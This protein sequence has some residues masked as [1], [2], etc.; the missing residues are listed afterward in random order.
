MLK[1]NGSWIA[2][3]LFIDYG[4]WLGNNLAK[5][6]NNPDLI[7]FGTHFVRNILNNYNKAVNCSNPY[8]LKIKNGVVRINRDNNF[9][10]ISDIMKLANKT[11]KSFHKSARG[12][13]YIKDQPDHYLS[14]RGSTSGSTCCHPKLTKLALDWC[15][16]FDEKDKVYAFVDEAL[17][18]I[19]KEEEEDEDEDED[20]E[21]EEAEEE[22]EEGENEEEVEE[23]EEDKVEDEEESKEDEVEDE[24]ESKEYE[25]EDESVPDMKKN[26]IIPLKDDYEFK[27]K[28]KNG[29]SMD[30]LIRR[31]GYVN[32]T[33]LCKAGNKLFKHYNENKQ[34]KEYLQAL[35]SVVGIPTTD[36]LDIKQGGTNQGTYVHRK[37]AYHLAQWIS[38]HFAVQVSDILDE[39][40][41]TGKVELGKEKSNEELEDIYSKKR[42]SL[43]YQENICKDVLYVFE[44]QPEIGEVSI[45]D[46]ND[47]H[48]FEFGVTSDIKQRSNAY[49]TGYRLDRVFEYS[50]GSKTSLAE[51]YVK[52]ITRDLGMTFEYKKKTECIKCKYEGLEKLYALIEEHNRKS[53]E[54]DDDKNFILEKMRLELSIET[55]KTVSK[56]TDMLLS[57]LEKGQ[58]TVNQFKD[59]M[60]V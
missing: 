38:P 37:V 28:L 2:K 18:R 12:S 31:D 33:Q 60:S 44:F 41:L 58:I 4:N 55:A 5:N 52:N 17:K 19:E 35:S 21:N 24:E 10:Y 51:K 46:K 32:A 50:N 36:L 7:G 15:P 22:G 11:V 34:T 43:D 14:V 27:L 20:E 23:V 49:G 57:L 56:K 48:Y 3:D 40:F 8:F 9:I 54:M 25:V 16:S 13:Q 26:L 47:I 42:L 59:L 29:S 30:V 45:E 6:E 1:T 39:L 53:N